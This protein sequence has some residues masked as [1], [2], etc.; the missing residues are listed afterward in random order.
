T[1]AQ[2]VLPSWAGGVM[3]TYVSLAV[4]NG[5]ATTVEGAFLNTWGKFSTGSGPANV[6]TWSGAPL[7]YYP[8]GKPFN[9]CTERAD[10]LLTANSGNG[11]CNSFAMLFMAALAMNGIAVSKPGE[12]QSGATVQQTGVCVNDNGWML[13]KNWT[14]DATKQYPYSLVFSS[15][16]GEMLPPPLGQDVP[17][18]GDLTNEEGKS[19]QNSSTPRT[20]PLIPPPVP[21]NTPSE[22]VFIAHYIVR[23][24]MPGV[25]GPYFDP[26]YGITYSD[27]A[28]FERDAVA[29]Y[30][31]EDTE[32]VNGL[33]ARKPDGTLNISF[34]TGA[35]ATS[36]TL[37]APTNN[38]A[39]LPSPVTFTWLPVSGPIRY[40]YLQFGTN[41]SPLEQATVYRIDSNITNFLSPPLAAGTTYRWRLA[42]E[43]C[44]YV[45]FS[46]IWS[47]TVAP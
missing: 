30:A 44:L 32:K 31:V 21:P 41:T 35:T 4:A 38:A 8:P 47:F 3:L 13:V 7:A 10:L 1:L 18:Y 16:R 19:G 33:I 15:L 9:S 27:E 22:K 5:G 37:I 29:G 40:Y 36:P 34:V 20:P 2:N 45:S 39:N 6:T 42:V 12:I 28:Q 14:F 11:Q 17:V 24:T 43:N 23:V 26:S 46:P 25:A